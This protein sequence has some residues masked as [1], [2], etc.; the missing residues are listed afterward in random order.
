[1]ATAQLAEVGP[2]GLNLRAIA[3]DMG[4]S[5][6]GIYRY[7]ESRDD[8]LV[9]LL[10]TG[11]ESLGR[12][13]ADAAGAPGHP[14]ERL[15]SAF[16][17]YRF[18][19][20]EHPQMFALLFTDPVPNFAAPVD[21]PTDRA[22]RA[23]MSPLVALGAELQG[24]QVVAGGIAVA[25]DLPAADAGRMLQTWSSVHGFVSLEVFHQMDWADIDVDALFD[26]HLRRC[27]DDL[28]R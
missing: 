16:R 26:D 9:S 7:F 25:Q 18:W 13:L 1:M 27:L 21:G 11:F 28:R 23:A 24:V 3:R 15:Q 10:A 20:K 17:A 22:V 5:S 12:E 14:A 8:L 19:A 2:T 4:M 6:A